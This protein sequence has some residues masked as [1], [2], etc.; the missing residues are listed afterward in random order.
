[1]FTGVPEPHV[2]WYFNDNI[3]SQS[4]DILR[5]HSNGTL[6]IDNPEIAD[7][8]QYSCEATNYLGTA[9]A[10]ADVKVNGKLLITWAYNFNCIIGIKD[11]VV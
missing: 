2:S 7:A 5:I 11:G 1:M 6:V 3:I 9:I 8:G 10:T 4:T